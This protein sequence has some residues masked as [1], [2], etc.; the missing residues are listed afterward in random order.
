[1][2]R[3]CSVCRKRVDYR[4]L[5][6]GRAVDVQGRV[7]CAA[8]RDEAPA[9]TTASTRG[10]AS[11]GGTRRGASTESGTRRVRSSTSRVSQAASGGS[12][13]LP[14]RRTQA[15]M[16]RPSELDRPSAA[17][18]SKAPMFVIGGLLIAALAGIG[19]VVSTSGG[20]ST[21]GTIDPGLTAGSNAVAG[22][23]TR[24]TNANTTAPQ[25][26]TEAERWRSL[27]QDAHD[28]FEQPSQRTRA[29]AD[30]WIDRLI[31][32][33]R[34]LSNNRSLREQVGTNRLEATIMRWADFALAPYVE[35]VLKSANDMVAAGD[36]QR[37]IDLLD[38]VLAGR[39]PG[40]LPTKY[41][42]DL[43]AELEPIETIRFRR[44]RIQQDLQDQQRR[45]QRVAELNAQLDRIFAA[46]EINA[47]EVL[48][49]LNE[50]LQLQRDNPENQFRRGLVYL[51]TNRFNEAKRDFEVLVQLGQ[52]F[53]GYGASLNN[54]I[55]CEIHFG[56]LNRAEA[57]NRDLHAIASQ[58][59]LPHTNDGIMAARRV[60]LTAAREH[61]DRAL[62]LARDPEERERVTNIRRNFVGE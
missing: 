5:E 43:E 15:G 36:S 61:F 12:G 3:Y 52:S 34:E 59:H 14:R 20:S 1:M 60:N 39:E 42:R 2:I 21:P 47:D 58:V 53:E 48:P 19:V 28:A 38:R 17:P 56:N 44:D 6:E 22:V 31:Q 40:L 50:V 49:L 27:I 11:E 57:L 37:A 26:P 23:N 35:R 10:T 7:Y 45:E 54:L 51:H 62:Q 41:V 32:V 24:D 16:S 25:L 30:E 55:Q 8:H 29:V 18:T 46:S 4:E 33:R 9:V 13:R